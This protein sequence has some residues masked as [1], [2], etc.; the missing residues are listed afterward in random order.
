MS[1][2]VGCLREPWKPPVRQR[3][4]RIKRN[5]SIC[6]AWALLCSLRRASVMALTLALASAVL[7]CT[8]PTAAQADTPLEYQIKAT[9]VHNFAKFIDWPQEAFAKPDS[10]IVVGIIGANPFGSTLDQL[11]ASETIQGRRVVVSRLKWDEDLRLCQMI[12]VSRTEQKHLQAILSNVNGTSTVT[13]SEIGGFASSGGMIEFV[14]DE[15]R[16][17]FDINPDAVSRARLTMSSKLISLAHSVT[18]QPIR[19]AN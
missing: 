10:P 8:E 17:R 5:E 16:I 9:F 15:R 12:F 11:S 4:R 14:F 3:R 19:S 18:K 2:G 1:A 13:I 7:I 6:A